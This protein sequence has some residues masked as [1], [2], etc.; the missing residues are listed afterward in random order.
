MTTGSAGGDDSFEPSSQSGRD[1]RLN[2]FVESFVRRES[3]SMS[4]IIFINLL[5]CMY[6]R[7][8]NL[9]IFAPSTPRSFGGRRTKKNG[10]VNGSFRSGIIII[11]F[12]IVVHVSRF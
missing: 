3:V 1:K 12:P 10:K 7:I 9:T 2:S 5:L 4:I 11:F 6:V 8:Y